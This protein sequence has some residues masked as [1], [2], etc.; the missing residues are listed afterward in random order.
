MKTRNEG[1]I[2][3]EHP[4]NLSNSQ[5][6]GKSYLH[7]ISRKNSKITNFFK[8]FKHFSQIPILERQI[9]QNC[10]E[11]LACSNSSFLGFWEVSPIS[12]QNCTSHFVQIFVFFCTFLA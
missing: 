1:Q 12:L 10:F 5:N 3:V 9:V 7:K 4:K 2:C 8:S 11:I 6:F